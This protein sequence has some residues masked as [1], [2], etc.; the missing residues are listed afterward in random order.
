MTDIKDTSAPE[1]QACKHTAG[2][3]KLDRDGSPRFREVFD[4]TGYRVCT[5]VDPRPLGDNNGNAQLI[6]SAPEL[7][8]SL[9]QLEAIVHRLHNQIESEDREA[10]ASARAAIAKATGKELVA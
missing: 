10:W 8:H 3:W 1:T 9:R 4:A 5:L 6:A 2:P 7:L